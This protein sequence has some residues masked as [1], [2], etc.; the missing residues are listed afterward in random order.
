M[1]IRRHQI[2]GL[3]PHGETMCLLDRVTK[4]D[5]HH[6]SAT[7]ASHRREDNPL[8]ENGRMDTVALVEYGAQ[9]AAIHAALQ[10]SGL[11]AAQP[12]Y[13][14]AIKKLRLFTQDI[15]GSVAELKIQVHLVFNEN[16]GAIYNIRAFTQE[17]ELM[18]G[19][20]VLIQPS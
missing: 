9:A 17:T 20:I 16:N 13:L 3:I 18:T 12:A 2:I 1:L 14:G 11:G 6:L 8:L 10:H 7:T 5:E 4:W 15:D 19:R